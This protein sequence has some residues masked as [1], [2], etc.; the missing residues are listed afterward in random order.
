MSTTQQTTSSTI[1]SEMAKG[2]DERIKWDIALT[3]IGGESN[4]SNQDQVGVELKQKSSELRF[5]RSSMSA[6]RREREH[7]ASSQMKINST[8]RVAIDCL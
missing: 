1:L 7:S 8:F 5:T 6:Q 4:V 2:Q 3:D